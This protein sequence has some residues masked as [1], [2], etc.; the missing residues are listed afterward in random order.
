MVSSAECASRKK[1]G[2][3]S[4]KCQLPRSHGGDWHISHAGRRRWAADRTRKEEMSEE[5]PTPSYTP[6]VVLTEDKLAEVVAEYLKW[7]HFVFDTET[8]GTRPAAA[9]YIPALDE[10]T[11]LPIWIGLALPG[12]VDIIPMGHPSIEG[13]PAPEQLSLP[14]VL[15]ALRP[16]FFSPRRKIAANVIFDTLTM[17]KFWGEIPPGPYGDLPVLAHTLNE[18][19]REY[20]VGTL[21][22]KYLGYTYRKLGREGAMDTF[23]FWDVARYV[24]YDAKLEHLTWMKLSRH[25]ERFPS[26]AR[27]FVLECDLTEV[28]I[29]AKHRGVL[30]D[31]AA[32]EG[33]DDFLVGELARLKGE[34]HAAAG[35]EFL[36]TSTQ[37]RA[38]VLYGPKEEGGLGLQC[39]VFTDKKAFS[40]S[41]EA[42][43]PLL[44]KH[45][46][47]PLLLK[48]A[49]MAKLQSTYSAGLLPHI[50]DD[51]RIRGRLNQRGTATGRMSSSK[52]NL[53]NISRQGDE[54]EAGHKVRSMFVAPPGYVLVVG[55]FAQIEYRVMG[56]FAGPLVKESL[57]LRA[58]N[59]NI[60]LHLLTAASLFSKDI[61]A[62]TK[63]ERQTGKT[64]NFALIF[65]GSPKRL[66]EAGLAKTEKQAQGLYDGF[67]RTYPEI[68]IYSKRLVQGCRAMQHPYVETLWGRRRRLPDIK[69]PTSNPELRK[70]RSYAERQAVNAVIQGTAA[71]INKA[72]MVRAFRRIQRGHLKGRAFLILTVH[73]EIILEVPERHA[74]EGVELLREAMQGVKAKLRTPLVADVH[75][76]KDWSTAK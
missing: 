55:D 19:L 5:I 53:Q 60:D 34:I 61:S 46:I 29:H 71:E 8:I 70:R 62:I 1:E 56:H 40:T 73:D 39:K 67:H 28:L 33:L 64:T 37:Q 11:N 20:D 66:L 32:L 54:E 52:P 42:L 3:R 58:F 12:R 2:E 27:L 68:E 35:Q 22:E 47:V 38:K 41:E 48:H 69:L 31:R 18:N 9:S 14:T 15:E 30:V 57:I 23:P 17:G 74:E 21:V 43:L 45:P 36:I 25:L 10:R 51:G 7:D 16:L 6:D 59:E 44:V 76:G 72:A 13:N 4:W 49:E 50:Q 75:Y 63:E 24:G 26:L 65:G